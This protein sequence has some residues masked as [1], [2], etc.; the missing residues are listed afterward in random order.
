M[1]GAEFE[2]EGAGGA[3]HQDGA[4]GEA[5]TPCKVLHRCG[6]EEQTRGAKALDAGR[7][8]RQAICKG[9]GSAP[10]GAAS[11]AGPPLR[12]PSTSRRRGPHRQR[13]GPDPETDGQW[14]QDTHRPSNG[15]EWAGPGAHL[16]HN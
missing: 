1:V 7:G 16:L 2:E 14:R 3:P 12:R 9:L 8:S 10:R 13:A 5:A 6:G 4:G 15:V 11:A